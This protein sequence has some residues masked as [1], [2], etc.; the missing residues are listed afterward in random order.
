M[1][2]LFSSSFLLNHIWFKNS[3]DAYVWACSVFYVYSNVIG[4]PSIALSALSAAFYAGPRD[5]ET[6]YVVTMARDRSVAILRLRLASQS[7]LLACEL[8]APTKPRALLPSPV[9]CSI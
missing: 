9:I 6:C 4:T 5:L 1:T 3:E 8:C 2:V 7:P